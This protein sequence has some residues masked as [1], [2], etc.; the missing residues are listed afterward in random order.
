LLGFSGEGSKREIGGL[1]QKSKRE[2]GRLLGFSGKGSKR[3]IGGLIA[4]T[5]SSG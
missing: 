5:M 1:S 4:W 3:E 2:I